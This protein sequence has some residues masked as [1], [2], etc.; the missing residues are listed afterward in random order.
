MKLLV[1]FGLAWAGA[2]LIC[3]VPALAN[4]ELEVADRGTVPTCSVT[5]ALPADMAKR[6][7]ELGYVREELMPSTVTTPQFRGRLRCARTLDGFGRTIGIALVEDFV[8]EGEKVRAL[9]QGDTIVFSLSGLTPAATYPTRKGEVRCYRSGAAAVVQCTTGFGPEGASMLVLQNQNEDYLLGLS[10]S[11]SDWPDHQGRPTA[12]LQFRAGE[13]APV[14]VDWVNQSL[15][16]AQDVSA[17]TA[18]FEGKAYTDALLQQKGPVP[19]EIE[20]RLANDQPVKQAFDFAE[21][22][23][24]YRAMAALTREMPVR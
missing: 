18:I 6:A 8:L 7:G 16:D 23:A 11:A 20:T 4:P 14:T 1:K 19:I 21:M 12:P 2:S 17:W 22:I 15:S 24:L 5:D 10:V 3:A 9:Y 13:N